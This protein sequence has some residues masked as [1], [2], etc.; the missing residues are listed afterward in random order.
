MS[1]FVTYQSQC[2]DVDAVVKAART[3][4]AK[5]YGKTDA[6]Q[7]QLTVSKGQ[8]QIQVTGTKGQPL[9]FGHGQDYGS[10][11]GKALAEELMREAMVEQ[12]RSIMESQGFTLE[13]RTVSPK[14]ELQLAWAKWS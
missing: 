14:G 10:V 8:A 6:E 4:D 12:T 1:R 2:V 9:V 7:I 11:G 13:S 5:L 3:I